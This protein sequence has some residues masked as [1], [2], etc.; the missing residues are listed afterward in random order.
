M[1]EIFLGEIFILNELSRKNF[2]VGEKFFSGGGGFM[3]E[4]MVNAEI[5]INR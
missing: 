5:K 1:A 4:I 3:V 2:S